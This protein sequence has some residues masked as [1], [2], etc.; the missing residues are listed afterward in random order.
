MHYLTG[1]NDMKKEKVNGIRNA[2]KVNRKA[3]EHRITQINKLLYR[4]SSLC[5]I[6]CTGDLA[7]TETIPNNQI[8][9]F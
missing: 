7:G 6:Y 2:V 3:R 4:A 8:T 9:T 5:I 1:Q